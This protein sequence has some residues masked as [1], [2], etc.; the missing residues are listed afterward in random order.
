MILSSSLRILNREKKADVMGWREKVVGERG[1]VARLKT[2]KRN[3][4][5]DCREGQ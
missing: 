1:K 5:R 3:R 4:S 2:G